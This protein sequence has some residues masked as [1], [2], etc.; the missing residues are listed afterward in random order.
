LISALGKEPEVEIQAVMLEALAECAGESGELVREFIPKMLETFEE[1][2]TESLERRA[3]RNKRASTEDFDEEEMEALEDEQAAEDEVF[4]Q[5]AEC[6]GTLLKSFKSNILAD[7]EPL[8]QSKIAPM[9]APERSAEERRIAICIFDDVFE[10]ASEGGATMKYL[11]GFADACV[12]G[13]ADADSDV[14]QAS[15]Y[16]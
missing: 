14:R 7:I 6:I 2:L 12:R 11:P 4:D 9:F 15:V 5:F 3:E 1:I 16:G 13:S 10:H 8:L